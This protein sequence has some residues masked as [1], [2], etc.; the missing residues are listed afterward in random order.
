METEGKSGGIINCQ[1][2]GTE[3]LDSSKFCDECGHN[4]LQ[5]LSCSK[6][7]QTFK[8]DAKFCAECGA[9]TYPDFDKKQENSSLDSFSKKSQSTYASADEPKW[10]GGNNN[11]ELDAY[12]QREF[13]MI[14]DS[15]ETYKGKWNWTA[16]CFGP[17]WA[18]SKGAWL[19]A[20]ICFVIC[21]ASAGVVGVI[22]WFVY[23]FRGNYIYYCVHQKQS[24]QVV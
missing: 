19:S 1:K 24:Q 8:P 18:I 2:C 12:Y 20:V 10:D 16:F 17:L 11:V 14:K 13:E 7:G 9:K 22:Y 6:C 3:N 5:N 15:G 21:I 4:L 23:G